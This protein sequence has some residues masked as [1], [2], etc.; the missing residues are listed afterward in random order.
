MYK[1]L[2]QTDFWVD[3]LRVQQ[4]RELSVIMVEHSQ[5]S[6]SPRTQAGVERPQRQV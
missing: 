6:G 3:I 2:L 1:A 5:G 4:R